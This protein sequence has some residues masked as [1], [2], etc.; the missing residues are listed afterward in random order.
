[1]PTVIT[2][3]TLFL[4]LTIVLCM[5]TI[6]WYLLLSP[7]GASRVEEIRR[8]RQEGLAVNQDREE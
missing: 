2:L 1:M 6:L 3:A 7:F 8:L 5:G 4:C